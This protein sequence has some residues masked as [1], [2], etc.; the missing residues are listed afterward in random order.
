MFSLP[1]LI[2]IGAA[3]A[4]TG[5]TALALRLFFRVLDPNPNSEPAI[6]SDSTAA[7]AE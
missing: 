6:S 3:L 7:G 2:V 4:A 1:L 5:L